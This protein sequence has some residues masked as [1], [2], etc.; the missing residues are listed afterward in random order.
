MRATSHFRLIFF[1]S[2]IWGQIVPS[3]INAAWNLPIWALPSQQ[4][5]QTIAK[6]EHLWEKFMGV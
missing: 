3:K 5:K 4:E 1:T 6:L 2:K